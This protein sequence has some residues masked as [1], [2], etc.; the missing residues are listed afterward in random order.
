[1]VMTSDMT[2]TGA[3]NTPVGLPGTDALK[4]Q[5]K[6]LRARL[7]TPEAPMSHAQAL[8]LVAGAHGYADWNTLSAAVKRQQQNALNT[9]DAQRPPGVGDAVAG[10]YLGQPFTGCVKGVHSLP[11]GHMR[12]TLHF[13]TPVDVVTFDSFSSFRQ[14]VSCTLDRDLVAPTRLSDGTPHMRIDRRL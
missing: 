1:M 13:D 3:P 14:R 8:E 7:D 11:G 12:L 4:A 2:K 10:T 9:A 5:A 6:R